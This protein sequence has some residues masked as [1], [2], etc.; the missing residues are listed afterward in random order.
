[1]NTSY[2]PNT[3]TTKLGVHLKSDGNLLRMA[4]AAKTQTHMSQIKPDRRD[5]LQPNVHA[6]TCASTRRGQSA[7]GRQVW[8]LGQAF[9]GS[10][11]LNEFR[12]YLEE[13]VHHFRL[14]TT[15]LHK[16]WYKTYM[17]TWT[18]TMVGAMTQH[19]SND[20]CRRSFRMT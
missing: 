7:T 14:A 1:M 20:K 18:Y 2:E 12:S 15:A 10:F 13:K 8:A 6:W 3:G 19:E 17:Q 4:S 16:L 11:G 9:Q 5:M